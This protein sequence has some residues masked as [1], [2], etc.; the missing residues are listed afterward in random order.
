M[1]VLVVLILAGARS[2]SM[3]VG[4][5]SG[6]VLPFP[7]T[8]VVVAGETVGFVR[9]FSPRTPGGRPFSASVRVTNRAPIDAVV[10]YSGPRLTIEM[11]EG[12][13]I[14]LVPES[15]ARRFGCRSGPAGP[16]PFI[17]DSV[18]G[19]PPS[20]VVFTALT[21]IPE[22]P[23][24]AVLDLSEPPP[25]IP[26]LDE[27]RC[28]ERRRSLW[29]GDPRA[30]ANEGIS[31]DDARRDAIVAVRVNAG[32]PLTISSVTRRLGVP[33]LKITRLRFLGVEAGQWDEFIEVTNL[34]GGP[35]PEQDW[36][37]SINGVRGFLTRVPTLQPGD[38]CRIATG[39]PLDG[40]CSSL[41]L[42]D[43]D[44]WPDDG[45]VVELLLRN[46]E[47]V[48][49]TRY[50]ANPKDQPPPPNLR[51]VTPTDP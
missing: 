19:D 45:A 14:Q 37:F 2:S 1:L 47:V 18:L 35:Q 42:G 46:D 38:V 48:D 9:E 39:R 43:L 4:A 15:Q 41:S 51:L 40:A 23:L 22:R 13:I 34:G 36:R 33:Y 29:D 6:R 8:T 25:C 30:W 49:R 20:I 7:A 50:S 10:T 17:C 11:P 16:A 24:E 28:D 32:D 12:W 21:H 26:L 3:R 5:Q 44:R 31:N 27:Q